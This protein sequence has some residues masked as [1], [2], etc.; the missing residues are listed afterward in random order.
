MYQ[1][2]L[3]YGEIPLTRPLILVDNRGF[4]SS[5]AG[6]YLTLKGFEVKMLF[7]GMAKWEAMLAKEKQPQ[8]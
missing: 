4:R 7:G 8:K 5:L 1:L 6:S 3:R 2:H